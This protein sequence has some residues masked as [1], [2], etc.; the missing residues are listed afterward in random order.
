MG[1]G[2]GFVTVWAGL[3]TA[4]TGQSPGRQQSGSFI[5]EWMG[6]VPPPHH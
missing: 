4:Q 2:Q 6:F 3:A 1:A 5:E